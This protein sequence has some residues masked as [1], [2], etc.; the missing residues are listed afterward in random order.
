MGSYDSESKKY[1]SNNL[2]FADLF[3]YLLYDGR[4]V[5]DPKELKEQ[6]V[7]SIVSVNGKN[8]ESTNDKKAGIS[9]QRYRDVLKLWEAKTDDHAVYILFGAEI[10]S[11]THYAM[12]VRNGLYDMLGYSKQVEDKARAYRNRHRKGNTSSED[13]YD[14]IC[15]EDG[16]LKVR[17][18]NAE[19]LSGLRKSD[20]IKPIITATVFISDE[21][22]DGPLSLH[23]MLDIEDKEL[24][25]FIPDYPVNLIAPA[26]IKDEDFNKFNTDLGFAMKVLKYQSSGADRILESTTEGPDG[27]TAVFL[28]KVADLEL[29]FDD[30]EEKVN[31]CKAMDN[32]YKKK[33]VAGAIKGMKRLGASDNDIIPEIMD[34]FDVTRQYVLDL[35]SPEKA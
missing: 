18:S 30:K 7:T 6:D 3:N 22:W 4:Q 15:V 25:K 32:A 24:L 23:D 27:E 11:N 5:I 26:Y 12:P 9:I 20:R 10:Q 14:S 19:F 21:E 1:F 28:N 2:Y 33:E 31:M 34:M 8:N 16:T 17:L 29:E 13:S 35:L